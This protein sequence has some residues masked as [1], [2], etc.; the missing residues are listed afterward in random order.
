MQSNLRTSFA[1]GLAAILALFSGCSREDKPPAEI[2][3]PESSGLEEEFLQ[4]AQALED[5]KN[6][7]F[8]RQQITALQ[9]TLRE[10]DLSFGKL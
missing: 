4:H 5:S 2:A 3:E 1:V 7:Y 6:R 10:A 8:G 9:L